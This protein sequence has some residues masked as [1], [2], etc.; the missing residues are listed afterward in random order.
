MTDESNLDKE[1]SLLDQQDEV[2]NEQTEE[3]SEPTET[4]AEAETQ[5]VEIVEKAKKHG[6]L[7]KDQY[8]AKYGTEDGFKTPEQFNKFG[9]SY[10]EVKD[11]LKGLKTKLE[12]REKEQEALVKYI[13]NV[14]NRE[15]EAAKRELLQAMKQA[16][17][18]G[19]VNAIKDLAK[20]QAQ[21]ELEEKQ[22]QV[23]SYH[24]EAQQAL[25]AFQD[26][27]K[28]WFNQEHPELVQRAHEIEKEILSGAHA[29]QYGIPVPKTYDQLSRQLEAAMKLEYP[30]IVATPQRKSAPVI[31]P[32]QSSVNKTAPSTQP[33]KVFNSLSDD[34]KQVYQATKRIAERNGYKYTQDDFIRK[35]KADG[36][37]E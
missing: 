2:V 1:D 30:D 28:H 37:I 10:D 3:V 9:E 24:Q 12:Q 19:D 33:N 4:T 17:D 5:P 26:R 27:N 13:D 34:L 15:R 22:Q 29:M 25:S 8:V 20:M 14:R 7:T 35:L 23:V 6:Y 36:E 16:E 32:A 18:E 21:Q 31:S 11:I